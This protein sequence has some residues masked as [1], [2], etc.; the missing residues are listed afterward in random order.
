MVSRQRL[1]WD[2]LPLAHF[3]NQSAVQSVLLTAHNKVLKHFI[4]GTASCALLRSNVRTIRYSSQHTDSC[5]ATPTPPLVVKNT[6]FRR[7]AIFGTSRNHNEYPR[8]STQH[9]N[10]L[11]YHW[12]TPGKAPKRVLWTQNKLKRVQQTFFLGTC[13]PEPTATIRW[14][15]PQR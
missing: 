8:I 3:P 7:S 10:V 12:Y 6:F 5:F 9:H 4:L 1:P 11:D 14:Y 15:L 13:S 2:L